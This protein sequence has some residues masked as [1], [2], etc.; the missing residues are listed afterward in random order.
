MVENSHKL[1]ARL[2][3]G[4]VVAALVM[5]GCG[6]VS[7]SSRLACRDGGPIFAY[8]APAKKGRIRQSD[9]AVFGDG[10]QRFLTTDGLSVH[11]SFSPDGSRIVFSS[12]LGG[13]IDV[14][15]IGYDHLRLFVA[16]STG[17]QRERLTSGPF[18]ADPDWSP[19][20]SRVVFV[21]DREGSFGAGGTEIWTIEVDT[22]EERLLM[23][24]PHEPADVQNVV[25]SPVW[26][27]DGRRIA[28]SLGRIKDPDNRG[29]NEVWVMENDGSN[30]R[31]VVTDVGVTSSTRPAWH[32][33]R[34]AAT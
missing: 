17:G 6:P 27:P 3:L 10:R 32:G 11:P 29:P 22:R 31:R 28:F 21:R 25:H 19:D 9:V 18:D 5:A 2:T 20:G 8:T 30:R 7:R 15:A 33:R 1:K 12:G 14:E 16:N 23:R 26:S 34:M 4:L 13:D 24:L